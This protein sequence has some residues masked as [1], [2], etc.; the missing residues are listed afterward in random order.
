M[1]AIR[2]HQIVDKQGEILMTDLPFQLGQQVEVI[3]LSQP[4]TKI[5]KARLTVGQFRQSGLIGLWKDRDDIGDSAVYA[6]QL[7][8]QA[9]QRGHI[10]L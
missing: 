9:Q 2:V 7:R 8:E 1:E 5:K 6:R 3:I 10:K 4:V